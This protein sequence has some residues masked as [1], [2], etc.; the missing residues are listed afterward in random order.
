MDRFRQVALALSDNPD[1]LLV[2]MEMILKLVAANTS[3]GLTPETQ[4]V[5]FVNDL[6]DELKVGWAIL[7]VDGTTIDDNVYSLKEAIN[8]VDVL[9]K[10]QRGS[11]GFIPVIKEQLHVTVRI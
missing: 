2:F 4:H 9:Y 3:G 7:K 11:Y 8:Q 5:D 1:H 6:A 10:K